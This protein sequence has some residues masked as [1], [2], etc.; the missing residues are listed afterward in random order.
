MA[1]VLKDRDMAALNKRDGRRLVAGA[2]LVLTLLL[3]ASLDREEG[4]F[5]I[6]HCENV[7][8]PLMPWRLFSKARDHW[9]EMRSN[10]DLIQ[11]IGIEDALSMNLDY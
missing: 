10:L 3:V 4:R 2:A 5:D 7:I 8:L 6:E 11:A 1:A 9:E